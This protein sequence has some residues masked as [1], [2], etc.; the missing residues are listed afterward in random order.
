MAEV[1]INNSPVHSDVIIT[2]P[3]GVYNPSYSCDFHTGL[4]FA[5]YGSTGTNPPIY[6]VYDGQVVQITTTGDLGYM[7]CIKDARNNYWRYCHM[8]AGSITVS[9][10][11]NVTTSTKIG[12]M[13]MTGNAT[14][15]PSSFRM[16][17]NFSMAM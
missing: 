8:V 14:R 5:P 15:N 2:N 16:F 9:V 7:V 10:G 17:N 4:D 12:N 13:G 3:Y 11:D 6:P 1:T